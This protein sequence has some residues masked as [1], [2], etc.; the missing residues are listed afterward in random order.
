MP[1]QYPY[2]NVQAR[3][4]SDNAIIVELRV[5]SNSGAT[6]EDAV[7]EAV[8]AYLNELPGVRVTDSTRYAVT[9]TALQ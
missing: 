7:I 5:V 1:M 9:E 2:V 6:D 3:D 4:A 8:R